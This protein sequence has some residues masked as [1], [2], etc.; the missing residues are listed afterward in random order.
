MGP[1][2][3]ALMGGGRT[4]PSRTSRLLELWDLKERRLLYLF[5]GLLFFL[6]S[7]VIV[8]AYL[9]G[10]WSMRPLIEDLI[11]SINFACFIM[12]IFLVGKFK[13]FGIRPFRRMWRDILYISL[14]SAMLVTLVFMLDV[15]NVI[16]IGL[17][18]EEFTEATTNWQM[19]LVSIII[20]LIFF[21]IILAI[22]GLTTLIMMGFVG[23]IGLFT[24]GL[25]PLDLRW[26]KR[27]TMRGH[28]KAKVLAWLLLIPDNLDTGT[29]TIKAPEREV[30][31][32]WK[33][34]W[35]A[36]AW[37][38][39]FNILV[40][41]YVSLNPFFLRTSTIEELVNLMTSGFIIVPIIVIPWLITERLD[42]RI[43]GP[44]KDFKLYEGIRS[45]L[46]RTFLALGT[47]MIF[48]R[49]AVEDIALERILYNLGGYILF[50]FVILFAI[51]FIYFNFYEYELARVIADRLP[52]TRRGDS[53]DDDQGTET[54]DV[55]DATPD[56]VEE[57]DGY[58]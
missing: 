52:W 58:S 8:G 11:G 28:F 48:V 5:F 14:I 34:F 19:V 27:I 17:P 9:S 26:V 10:D 23:V 32:P 6:W 31:F 13:G 51:T 49:F 22:M 44:V 54:G 20:Y 50:S 57:G 47:L 29:L 4:T 39:A 25:I 36:L 38:V 24:V 3:S 41:I 15:T 37:M 33:R 40:A 42:A 45:R 18:D 1:D 12:A 2:G 16:D 43:E 46:L 53:I 21:I 55:V 30:E 56:T 35:N 7:G